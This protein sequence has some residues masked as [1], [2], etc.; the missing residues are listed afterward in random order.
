MR[1]E[2]LEYNKYSIWVCIACVISNVSYYPAMVSSG[3]GRMLAIAIWILLLVSLIFRGLSICGNFHSR[4][5]LI[6]YAIFGVNTAVT[7]LVNDVNSFSNH[8]FQIVTIS[9][10]ILIVAMRYGQNFECKDLKRICIWYY[11]T[12]SI[13]SLPLFAFYLR[14]LDL[15]S[16]FYDFVFGKNEI[17]VMLLCSLIIGL[18][19]Y[20]PNNCL[21]KIFKIVSILF[22]LIDI[23]YLRCR[24]SFLG[25]VFLYTQI[26]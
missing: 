26:K 19:L 5:Y 8:F 18:V 24:S 4:V 11:V 23:L 17:A 22:L 9:T 21:K 14:S 1:K 2:M 10:L 3:I 12:T 16:S 13:M 15:N 6:L 7:G 25:V 20:E